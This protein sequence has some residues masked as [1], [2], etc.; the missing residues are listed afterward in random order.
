MHAH[1]ELTE[2]FLSG[3]SYRGLRWL[4]YS[5]VEKHKNQ[6]LRCFLNKGGMTLVAEDV[7]DESWSK[8]D[9]ILD[10]RC[11]YG[12]GTEYYVKWQN[13]PY[14][15]STWEKEDSLRDD[16]V[17]CPMRPTKN[18]LRYTAEHYSWNKSRLEPYVGRAPSCFT[19]I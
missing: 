19:C 2:L 10:K 6:S 8:V 15:D 11:T 18:S 12:G 7:I 4:P 14:A 5:V 13:L 16:M 9:R 3:K 1:G 17:Q